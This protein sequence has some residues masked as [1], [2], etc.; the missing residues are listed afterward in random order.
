MRLYTYSVD[1]SFIISSLYHSKFY[2]TSCSPLAIIRSG[3]ILLRYIIHY[4]ITP[5]TEWVRCQE[6]CR[7]VHGNSEAKFH[8]QEVITHHF[9]Q[10]K[11]CA[12]FVVRRGLLGCDRSLW[13]GCEKM[14]IEH[15]E[16]ILMHVDRTCHQFCVTRASEVY[17]CKLVV[18]GTWNIL[19]KLLRRCDVPWI[20]WC[21]SHMRKYWGKTIKRR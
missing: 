6:L 7:R 18:A 16:Q 20:Y 2:S 5:S 11:F 17:S 3:G 14:V 15:W 13:R 1:D 8:G 10:L 19:Y 9:F 21:Y 12:W 4:L